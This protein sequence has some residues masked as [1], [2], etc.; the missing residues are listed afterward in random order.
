M[1]L[2]ESY[3]NSSVVKTFDKEYDIV[4]T[5]KEHSEYNKVKQT[6]LTRCKI[7]GE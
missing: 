1:R 3:S 7:K 5:V 4:G 2:A 6:V